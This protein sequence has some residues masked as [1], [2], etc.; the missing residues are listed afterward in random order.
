MA[1]WVFGFEV[2]REREVWVQLE[3][4][5]FPVLEVSFQGMLFA[6]KRI[7]HLERD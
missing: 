1:K 4:S 6:C 7:S 5:V 2:S 3:A